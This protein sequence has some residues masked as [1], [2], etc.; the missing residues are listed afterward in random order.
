MNVIFVGPTG[1]HHALIAAHIFMGDLHN[2]DYSQIAYYGDQNADLS[3]ELIYVGQAEEGVQV[4]TFGAGRNHELA[5]T[6]IADFRDLYGVGPDELVARVVSVPGYLFFYA[7]SYIPAFLGGRYL[8][9]LLAGYLTVKQFEHIKHQTLSLKD[10]LRSM[11][12]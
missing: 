3:G 11:R 2:N 1:V 9:N 10:E 8:S 4:Y 7:L 12:Q 5:S 6:I